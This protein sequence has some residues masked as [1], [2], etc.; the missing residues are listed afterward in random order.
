MQVM[1]DLL[2][3][4]ADATGI[5]DWYAARDGRRSGQVL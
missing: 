1:A 3:R 5:E 4:G 2:R